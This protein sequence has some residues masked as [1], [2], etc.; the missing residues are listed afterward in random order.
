M[1]IKIYDSATHQEVELLT[2]KPGQVGI[3]LCGATVQSSPHIGHIRSALA[4]DVLHRWIKRCGYQ[5]NFVR[6]VTDIDD[7]ILRKS[8]EAGVPWWA[9]ATKFEREFSQAYQ[10][11]GVI[12]PIIEPRATG[13]MPEM[14]ELISE[15]MEAGHAYQGEGANVYFDVASLPEYGQLTNQG[16][17]VVSDDEDQATDKRDPRDF[18]LWKAAKPEEPAT[19]SWPSPWGRG[20]PGWHLECSAMAGRYLGEEFDIHAGG[21]ELRFPHHE[22]E[23]AQSR[24][25]GRPFARYWMHNAW[26]TIKGE[27]MSK[28]LG[29][30]L[31]VSEILQQ[32]EAPVLRLALGTVHY[33]ATVEYSPETLSDAAATWE[34][35]AGFVERSVQEVGVVEDIDLPREQLPAAFVEAMDDDLNIAGAMAVIYE[36]LKRGNTALGHD[37]DQQV[38]QSQQLIRSMLDVFGLDPLSPV[39]A[40]TEAGGGAGKDP[41]FAALDTLVGAVLEERAAARKAKDWERADV[42]RAQLAAAGIVV[43]DSADGARWHLD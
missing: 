20:R 18:A 42:L 13:H 23:R 27:K 40:R 34:R 35:L 14:I 31:V 15:I 33:R 22:N 10:A 2:V 25:V 7:K 30:S 3:Y 24:S 38:R 8:A 9:W 28:S 29:N 43:E 26:V 21:I 6:N 19:A 12:P 4:F 17:G 32:V 39:W 5:V 11:L 36:E 41:T 1:S 37:D 16:Q